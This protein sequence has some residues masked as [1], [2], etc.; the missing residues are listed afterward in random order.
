MV[1]RWHYLCVPPPIPHPHV[2]IDA[3]LAFA[4]SI[5]LD[6]LVVQELLEEQ[7]PHK[8]SNALH[9]ILHPDLKCLLPQLARLIDLVS[10]CLQDLNLPLCE[11]SGEHIDLLVKQ[12]CTRKRQPS[13][14]A[15]LRESGKSG[16]DLETRRLKSD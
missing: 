16:R 12:I 13:A 14:L 3:V 11:P 9:R 10:G 2:I 5:D 1:S 6:Q 7:I 4:V 15:G 8:L